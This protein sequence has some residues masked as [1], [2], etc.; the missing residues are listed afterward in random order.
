[1]TETEHL[2]VQDGGFAVFRMETIHTEELMCVC[3]FHMQVCMDMA[4]F[5]VYPCVQECHIVG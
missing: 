4:V 5:Q 1:M 3:E 2:A